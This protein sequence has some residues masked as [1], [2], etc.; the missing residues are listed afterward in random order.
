M[1]FEQLIITLKIYESVEKVQR[2]IKEN[3]LGIVRA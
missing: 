3:F 2:E 1:N